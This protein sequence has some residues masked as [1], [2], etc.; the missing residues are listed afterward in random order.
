MNISYSNKYLVGIMPNTIIL[1]TGLALVDK[2]L[3]EEKTLSPQSEKSMHAK[4][5]DK[6]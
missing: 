1:N 3:P 2:I 5:S 4:V 6:T